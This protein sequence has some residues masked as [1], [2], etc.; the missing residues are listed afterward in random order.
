MTV[1]EN[2]VGIAFL[3]QY[4]ETR[5]EVS[6]IRM[7]PSVPFDADLSIELLLDNIALHGRI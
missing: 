3:D 4:A 2:E 6:W 7:T 5:W 1:D